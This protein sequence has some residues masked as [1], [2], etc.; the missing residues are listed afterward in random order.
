MTT[1]NSD[2]LSCYCWRSGQL[3]FDDEV[4]EGALLLTTHDPKERSS[5]EALARLSYDGKT[6]L[7]PGIP[8]AEND[9]DAILAYNNFR[10]SIRKLLTK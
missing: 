4:P 5:I 1:S 6:F 3:E 2:L 9:A 7:V 8:E 10:I